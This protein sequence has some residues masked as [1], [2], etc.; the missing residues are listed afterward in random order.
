MPFYGTA[1]R[2]R[3][4]AGEHPVTMEAQILTLGVQDTVWDSHKGRHKRGRV[5]PVRDTP[6][7]RED[8][9]IR[10]GN[11]SCETNTAEDATVVSATLGADGVA[12]QRWH[13]PTRAVVPLCRYTRLGAFTLSGDFEAVPVKSICVLACHGLPAL[14]RL[15]TLDLGG[16]STAFFS[17]APLPTLCTWLARCPRLARLVLPCSALQSAHAA[18]LE[19]GDCTAA[20]D[21]S[22]AESCIS[23]RGSAN[24]SSGGG[25]GCRGSVMQRRARERAPSLLLSAALPQLMEL[26]LVGQLPAAEALQLLPQLVPALRALDVPAAGV[27]TARLA[28]ALDQLEHLTKLTVSGLDC[29]DPPAGVMLRNWGGMQRNVRCGGRGVPLA[30]PRL[31]GHGSGSS[32]GVSS[33][34]CC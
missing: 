3:H 32:S 15:H 22:D 14:P 27:P 5:T 12:A 7:P 21:A 19:D 16:A 4:P 29:R 1:T 20:G 26:A 25:G 30:G 24:S 31:H 11:R 9:V 34:A 6:Q 2:P 23:G 13:A 28:S 8:E 17:A 18:L 33:P 10:E